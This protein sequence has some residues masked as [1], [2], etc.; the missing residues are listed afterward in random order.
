MRITI[1]GSEGYVGTTLVHRLLKHRSMEL[2]DIQRIDAC[3]WRPPTSGNVRRLS[4][5]E[6]IAKAIWDFEPDHIVYL[7]ALA[8]DPEGRVP[9]WVMQ[10]HTSVVTLEVMRRVQPVPITVI[11][12]L[13]VFAAQ[14]NGYPH[15]KRRLEDMIVAWPYW[16]QCVNIFRFGTLFGPPSDHQAFR[17]HLLLNKMVAD[18]SDHGVIQVNKPYLQRPVTYLEDAVSAIYTDIFLRGP[19]GA[20]MNFYLGSATILEYA[21]AVKKVFPED[22]KIRIIA[23]DTAD[24]RDYG[25]GLLPEMHLHSLIN[26]Q[27]I[28]YEE[29]AET[30]RSDTLAQR[31]L[32][33]FVNSEAEG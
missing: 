28:W 17:R 6:D 18:A 31:S 21:S 26:Q 10:K 1:V 15:A 30:L 3:V 5:P 14:R 8:H 9:D 4:E 29:Y 2:S 19:A 13:S 16:R 11:S 7:N 32:Q 33:E 23:G 20:I 27:R 12:S 25:W 22:E 24:T